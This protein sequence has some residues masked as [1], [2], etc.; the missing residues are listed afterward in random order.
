MYPNEKKS[1]TDDRRPAKKTTGIAL[2]GAG[3]DE[4]FADLLDEPLPAG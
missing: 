2:R 4:P 1:E 3:S